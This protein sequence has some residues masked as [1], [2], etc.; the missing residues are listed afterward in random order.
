MSD[1]ALSA[2]SCSRGSKKNVDHGDAGK[3]G[4]K[5]PKWTCTEQVLFDVRNEWPQCAP[6]FNKV[7][8]QS[9][10]GSCWAVATASV[11]SD[12]YCVDQIKKRAQNRGDPYYNPT[13]AGAQFSAVELLS[14]T[15]N[16]AGYGFFYRIILMGF[17]I[18]FPLKLIYGKKYWFF[19]A[20]MI[21]NGKIYT[22]F[23]MSDLRIRMVYF[24]N[25]VLW[26]K[27]RLSLESLKVRFFY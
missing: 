13:S 1:Q 19:L 9:F 18:D 17:K 14:C 16:T 25:D 27:P 2:I 4:V 5:T 20:W 22:E 21:S 15:P 10:C 7:Q 3:P 6:V 11:F 23:D 12:R 8:D 24:G 26:I